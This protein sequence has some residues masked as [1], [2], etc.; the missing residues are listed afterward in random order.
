[1]AKR[2]LLTVVSAL[3]VHALLWA[4]LPHAL[5]TPD[6]APRVEELIVDVEPSPIPSSTSEE[7][8][9][10]AAALAAAVTTTHSGAPGG[11]YVETGPGS[12]ELTLPP[13]GTT[14]PAS[15][16]AVGS[17]GGLYAVV[18]AP[19]ATQSLGFSGPGS[20]RASA[21]AS[22]SAN[23]LHAQVQHALTDPLHA[24]DLELG[25]MGDG[26][27]VSALQDTTRQNPS[28]LAGHAIF[29]VTIDATG[30]VLHIGVESSSGDRSAWDEIARDSTAA[31]LQRKLRVPA[32]SRGL[33]LRIAVDSDMRLPSGAHNAIT[34][35]GLG[36]RFDISDLGSR[37]QRVVAAHTLSAS[38]L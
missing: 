11:G 23:A 29:A 34:P 9:S 30:T 31:L 33:A 18:P 20:Y 6:L 3:G 25:L 2:E 13:S 22:A 21:M 28:P 1:M 37:P 15:S 17:F 27:V 36:G 38:S 12:G 8:P 5:R 32:G 7:A 19:G 24:R 16:A 4:M 14:G 10:P 35:E 26:P